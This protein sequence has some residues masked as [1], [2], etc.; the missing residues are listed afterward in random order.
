MTMSRY[1]FAANP[2]RRVCSSVIAAFGLVTFAGAAL[3]DESGASFWQPGTYDSFS[4]VPS[5]PGWSLS[6]SEFHSAAYAGSDVTAAR[7]IRTGAIQETQTGSLS[8][9]SASFSNLLTVSPSY[10]FQVPAL[11]A[12]ASLSVT[13]VVGKSSV[14]EAGVLQANL[15]SSSVAGPF[16]IGDSVTG[17]GDFSPQATLYWNRDVHNFMIYGTGNAPVGAYKVTRLA[18]LGLGHAAVDGGGGYTYYDQGAGNE[19]SAV[20]GFTYNMSNLATG[21][22]SGVDFHLDLGASKH[23]TESLLVGPVGYFYDEIGCDSGSGDKVGC[24]RSRVAGLG[25]QIGHSFPFE[26]AQGYLNLKAYGEFAEA[27]RPSGWTA[28]VTFSI[29][30]K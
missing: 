22:R 13:G 9:T 4:A 15:G 24:F 17:F 16:S 19:F 25:A 18:N 26:A 5:Q 7:L 20:A 14:S 1:P 28:R 30:P 3:A 10:V 11:D 12:K 6:T 29:S 21:Y 8:A 27:N 2:F 23:L